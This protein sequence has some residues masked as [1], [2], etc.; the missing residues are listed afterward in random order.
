YFHK[1][2]V[3]CKVISG[4]DPIT[5]SSIAKKA[6]L[7]GAD[8]YIDATTLHTKE[9]IKEAVSKYHI[10]GRVTPKQKKEMVICLK[11]L[12]H[13][14]AMTGDGVN[15]VLAFKE[16]DCSI[17]MAAGSDAAKKAANLVLLDNNFDAMPHIVNE[18]RRVINNISLSASMFLVKTI[19]S[20]FIVIVTLLVGQTYP[21]EPIQLSVI[22]ACCVGI[23]SFFLTYESNFTRVKGSFLKNVIANAF[24]PALTISVGTSIIMN[25]GL[26]LGNPKDMLSTMCVIFTAWNYL[27]ALKTIYSPLSTYRKYVMYSCQLLYF[28]AMVV[29]QD[30]LSLGGLGY[31]ALIILVGILNFSRLFHDISRFIFD[32][33]YKQFVSYRSK[34]KHNINS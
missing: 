8:A 6:G 14:V 26:F 33:G 25:V 16:A 22:S 21:F 4:D 7:H 19:F 30:I 5:V 15:D 28:V 11:E 3:Q 32:F 18:G 2:G 10:F 29:G 34:K 13:T 31:I 12:G 23:P 17:A 9:E 24:P 20:T 1:Q 27:L